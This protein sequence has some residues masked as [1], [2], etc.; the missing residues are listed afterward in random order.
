ME[1]R[2]YILYDDRAADGNVNDASVL[3]VCE[4]EQEAKSYEGEFGGMSCYSYKDENGQL[5]DE[6]HEW[7]WYAWVK[8][9]RKKK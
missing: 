9:K 5:V 2:I 4:S 7:N 6:R 8:R 3:V 1:K